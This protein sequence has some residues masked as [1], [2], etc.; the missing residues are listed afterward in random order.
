MPWA[1]KNHQSVITGASAKVTYFSV[2]PQREKMINL[3]IFVIF[4]S[5][6]NDAYQYGKYTPYQA[7]VKTIIIQN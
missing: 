7:K 2:S 1:H 6:G 3:N 5:V 4:L